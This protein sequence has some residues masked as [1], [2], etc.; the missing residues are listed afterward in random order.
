MKFLEKE[1]K[2]LEVVGRGG[3]GFNGEVGSDFF[4][5]GFGRKYNDDF[6][7]F[8]EAEFV[9]GFFFNKLGRFHLEEEVLQVL[10]F[11]SRGFKLGLGLVKTVAGT[12][13]KIDI[14]DK[15]KGEPDGQ[16]K[17]GNFE[18]FGFFRHK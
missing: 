4:E 18:D 12:E 5:F 10:M 15:S 13:K 6:I 3:L 7:G 9:A 16:E 14:A 2:P 8:S 17:G 1:M 11:N